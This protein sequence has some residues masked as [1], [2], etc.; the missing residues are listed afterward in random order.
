MRSAD[1]IVVAELRHL[2]RLRDRFSRSAAAGHIPRPNPSAS[3]LYGAVAPY[4]DA[5]VDLQRQ[6]Q[7]KQAEEDGL[8]EKLAPATSRATGATT[9]PSRTAP[10]ARPRRSCSPPAPSRHARRHGRSQRTSST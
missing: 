7:S 5:L 3:P 2:A 9:R 4:E 1:A 10:A 8:K 6:L